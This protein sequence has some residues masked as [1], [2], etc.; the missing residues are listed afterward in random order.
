VE[1]FLCRFWD[2]SWTCHDWDSA[3][4]RQPNFADLLSRPKLC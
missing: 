4:Q 2:P 1:V 3:D